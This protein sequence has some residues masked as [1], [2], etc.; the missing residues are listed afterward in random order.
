M[1]A[2]ETSHVE[3]PFNVLDEVCHIPEWSIS[4]S[5]H[6]PISDIYKIEGIGK[7]DVVDKAG[8]QY[9]TS[10]ARLEKASA[11]GSATN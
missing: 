10:M 3:T 7:R 5:M 9:G 8:A 6:M 4:A 11:A 2:K 1:S